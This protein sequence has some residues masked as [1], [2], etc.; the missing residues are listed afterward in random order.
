MTTPMRPVPH[1][2]ARWITR[3]RWLRWGDALLAWLGLTLV[4]ALVLGAERGQAAA[5]LALILVGLGAALQPLRVR[6][7]PVTAW[8]GLRISRDLRPGD[9]C[10]YLSTHEASRAVVTARHGTRLVIVRPDLHDEGLSVRRTRVFLLAVD[11]P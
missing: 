7:R 3:R 4:L 2:V 8:V 9:R 11:E 1:S 10:W 5:V 6:W